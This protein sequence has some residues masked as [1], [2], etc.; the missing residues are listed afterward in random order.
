MLED[1]FSDADEGCLDR[2]V[3]HRIR[4]VAGDGG[5]IQ[6]HRREVGTNRLPLNALDALASGI[7]VG[8]YQ[9]PSLVGA[10]FR[11]RV[12]ERSF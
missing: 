8:G 1:P 3:L 2:E 11:R 5:E 4:C 6:G 12:C 9:L 7:V 10:T